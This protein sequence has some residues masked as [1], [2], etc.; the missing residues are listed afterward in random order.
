MAVCEHLQ[1]KLVEFRVS[2]TVTLTEFEITIHRLS[3]IMDARQLRRRW[4]GALAITTL[5]VQFTTFIMAQ[6][7]KEKAN[8][9]EQEVTALINYLYEH[10]AEAGDGGSFKNTTFNAAA[11]HIGPFLTQGPPKTAKRC[12]TKWMAVCRVAIVKN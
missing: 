5:C 10:R 3:V 7:P 4:A 11:A 1:W 12:K 6:P 8:W 2:M 9:N